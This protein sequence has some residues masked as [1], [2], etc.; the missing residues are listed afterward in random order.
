[1]TSPCNTNL[2]ANRSEYLLGPSLVAAPVVRSDGDGG[3]GLAAARVWVPPTPGGLIELSTGKRLR[4]AGAL[5]DDE[6]G[7]ASSVFVERPYALADTPLFALS[8]AVVVERADVPSGGDEIIGLAARRYGARQNGD[9]ERRNGRS[10]PRVCWRV[11]NGRACVRGDDPS[12]GFVV[13]ISIRTRIVMS[14]SAPPLLDARD[15]RTALS[16]DDDG[17]VGGA[18]RYTV[19]LPGALEGVTAVYEDDG[20]TVAYSRG[21]DDDDAADGGV[22]G[23]DDGG[24]GAVAWTRARWSRA[25]R[26]FSFE[27]TSD[28][29]A[30]AAVVAGVLPAERASEL[31]RRCHCRRCLESYCRC[32]RRF[33]C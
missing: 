30:A 5:N 24:S 1:M 22:A 7:G 26:A 2:C 11:C 17:V 9:S 31:V 16:C 28:V 13:F 4:P 6:S 27:L 32:R 23:G 19:Y 29:D 21:V 12:L 25:G 20:G 15:A 3:A 8:G 14:C 18:L 10:P 33:R